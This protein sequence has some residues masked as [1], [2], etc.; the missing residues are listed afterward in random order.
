M[1]VNFTIKQAA[2]Y[3]ILFCCLK[4]TLVKARKDDS[5]DWPIVF[6]TSFLFRH[7][8]RQKKWEQKKSPLILSLPIP[9]CHTIL[10]LAA[11]AP[12]HY[13]H[14]ATILNMLSGTLQRKIP[15][16]CKLSFKFVMFLPFL[17]CIWLFFCNKKKN[18]GK[19]AT[20]RKSSTLLQRFQVIKYISLLCLKEN[21]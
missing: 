11:A 7:T 19:T 5:F 2:C 10:L 21:F 14:L 1:V 3:G 4:I 15:S 18:E 9:S 17:L 12:C 16:S 8:D 6:I 20:K 13:P